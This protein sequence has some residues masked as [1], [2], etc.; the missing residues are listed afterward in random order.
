MATLATTWHA[1]P[2]WVHLLLLAKASDG[3]LPSHLATVVRVAVYGTTP[4]RHPHASIAPARPLAVLPPYHST[5]YNACAQPQSHIVLLHGWGMSSKDWATTAKKLAHHHAVLTLDFYG[6]GASPYLPQN[7]MHDPNVL[8]H[9]VR[10]AIERAGWATAQV[11]IAGISMGSAIALRYS[12]RHPDSVRRLI[13]LCGAGMAVSRWY[14]LTETMSRWNNAM[15]LRIH[16]LNAT[17][18]FW[19]MVFHRVSVLRAMISH[20][21]LTRLTPE[22]GVNQ[23]TL[24]AETL[25][26]VHA[27]IWPMVDVLHPLQL[28]LFD[29]AP[30]HVQI[31]PGVDHALF[32]LLINDLALHAKP[33]LWL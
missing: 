3:T 7:D 18:P 22:Y 8:V 33:E 32:C 27:C 28:E 20:S 13:L 21:Y 31:V 30:Q 12:Q 4:R 19:H 23:A 5:V 24:Q 16:E 9:Q 2:R 14:A 11:T 25:A 6:H 17:S 26:K 15:L 29:E 10:D 1:L